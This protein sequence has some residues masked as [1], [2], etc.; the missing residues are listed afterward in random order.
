MFHEAWSLLLPAWEL[1]PQL[2]RPVTLVYASHSK[3]YFTFIFHFIKLEV[4]LCSREPLF[5]FL[6]STHHHQTSP[7]CLE[8]IMGI[9]T[10]LS[11][12]FRLLKLMM[13]VEWC[14]EKFIIQAHCVVC[15]GLILKNLFRSCGPFF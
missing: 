10:D 14:R 3:I 1:L 4:H 7:L 6:F 15:N 11:L 2:T 9:S 5:F 13:G 12:Q 8:E